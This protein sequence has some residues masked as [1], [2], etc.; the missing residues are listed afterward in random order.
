MITNASVQIA[1]MDLSANTVSQIHV[2]CDSF[3]ISV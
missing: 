1:I 3:Q 2:K